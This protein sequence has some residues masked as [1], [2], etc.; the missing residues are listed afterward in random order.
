MFLPIAKL[1]KG[2]KVN[3]YNRLVVVIKIYN[4]ESRKYT[5]FKHG[6]FPAINIVSMPK[7]I[8]SWLPNVG[9]QSG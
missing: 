4:V 6:T 3:L 8:L 2:N 5:V 9:V 7:P 1:R